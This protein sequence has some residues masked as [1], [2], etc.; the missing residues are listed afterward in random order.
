MAVSAAG[1]VMKNSILFSCVL[2]AGYAMCCAALAAPQ[3]VTADRMI[4]PVSGRAIDSPALIVED[5]RITAV[6]TQA[7]LAA[8]AGADPVDL[9]G[10]IILPGL[11]DMHTH[12][13]GDA[14]V[15]GYGGLG[16]SRDRSTIFGVVN[17]RKTLEAGVTT[18]RNVGGD[19]FS[20]VAL[21]DAIAEGLAPGP[22][23]FVSGPP[24]GIIGGHCS[25]NNLLPA[26][27][28]DFGAGVATGPWEM[29]AKVRINIKHGADLIKTCS[30]GG[31][32]SKGTTPGAEQNTVEEMQAIVAEA[33]QRGLKVASHAH[34]VAGVKNAIRAGVDTIEHASYLDNEAIRMAKSGGVYL[35]MDIYNT[36]YTQAEGRKNGALEESIRKDA[37]IA[38]IQRESFRAAVKAGAK[39]LYGTDSGVY[40]HGD[41]GKQFFY[42]VK[43]GMTPIQAIQ[44]ATSL[45]AEAL[46]KAGELG[47]LSAGCRADIIAVSGDPLSDVTALESVVFVMKDGEI[48]KNE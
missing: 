36:E 18:A 11:I 3:Y 32:F 38:E 20:D 4:D 30:T 39:V 48:Y 1:C 27:A 22:R 41:N 10:K 14:A 31:V 16:E 12:L 33:H 5:G 9:G 46:G 43:Y 35:V 15:G 25:D 26:D 42:M 7:T 6:G 44:A 45:A 24:V 47:C 37:E 23:L 2:S 21:R 8:P 19:N 29:R 17:A 28:K 34:G 40:P 13:I